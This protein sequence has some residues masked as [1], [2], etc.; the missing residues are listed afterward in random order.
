MDRLGNVSAKSS[1][2][3]PAES[4][5]GG[6]PPN[7]LSLHSSHDEYFHIMS[8]FSLPGSQVSLNIF[9]IH[10]NRDVW[11]DPEVC[12]LHSKNGEMISEPRLALSLDKAAHTSM[13][14]FWGGWVFFLPFIP[15]VRV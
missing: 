7:T 12:H 13:P 4:R 2:T 6:P 11:E 5:E 8:I 3:A 1:A 14:Y 9:G 15:T 10:R